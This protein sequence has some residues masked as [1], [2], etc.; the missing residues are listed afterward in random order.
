MV[1]ITGRPSLL[2][3]VGHFNATHNSWKLDPVSL[4]FPLKG[5]LPY[6][7][8]GLLF[9]NHGSVLRLTPFYLTVLRPS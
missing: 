3:V 5:L 2:P 8:V 7:K 4:M 9:S 1:S 6:D